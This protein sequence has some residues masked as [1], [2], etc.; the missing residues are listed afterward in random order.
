MLTAKELVRVVK[1]ARVVDEEGEGAGSK[2]VDWRPAG[3]REVGR[4]V[5]RLMRPLTAP[6]VAVRSSLAWAEWR[7][8]GRVEV[9][10]GG[11]RLEPGNLPPE[12]ALHSLENSG[13]SLNW[14]GVPLSLQVGSDR[15]PGQ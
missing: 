9:T 15:S 1:E 10:R 13:L 6:R 5:E 12:D 14:A 8:G 11:G 2:L 4:R 3:E 7:G